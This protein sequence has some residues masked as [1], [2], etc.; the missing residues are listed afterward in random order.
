VLQNL[1]ANGLSTEPNRWPI[2]RAWWNKIIPDLAAATKRCTN[3][4]VCGERLIDQTDR[5]NIPTSQR[6]RRRLIFELHLF[7]SLLTF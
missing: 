4:T 3:A 6:V 1:T 2:K 5:E 7:F